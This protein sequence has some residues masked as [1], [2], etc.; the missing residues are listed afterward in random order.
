MVGMK[1]SAFPTASLI[2]QAYM[3]AAFLV[4]V[5]GAAR[6][7][8]VI[9][10][11]DG[12]LVEWTIGM[13]GVSVAPGV[14]AVDLSRFGSGN[15]NL[16]WSNTSGVSLGVS[17]P[18]NG[19]AGTGHLD[20]PSQASWTG[21]Y[22][23]INSDNNVGGPG[24]WNYAATGTATLTLPAAQQYFGALL[25]SFTGSVNALA[26]YNGSVL[27]D[28]INV[29]GLGA[30]IPTSV[31]GGTDY[32]SY[33]NVDFLGGASYTK[34]VLTESGGTANHA[35]QIVLGGPSMSAAAVSL[36]SLTSGV[37]PTFD[38]TPLPALGGSAM[39]LLALAGIALP[40]IARRRRRTA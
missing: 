25:D 35:N 9:N 40:G 18:N 8:A 23:F 37:A 31:I 19:G 11:D 12:G 1:K 6:A 2:V 14:S 10:Q 36:T 29:T 7:Q 21:S 15:G 39:G 33:L 3:A 32:A 16:A 24:T 30:F 27:V 22:F 4:G 17:A 5:T 38:P 26:F 28:T 20:T 13:N 34:V